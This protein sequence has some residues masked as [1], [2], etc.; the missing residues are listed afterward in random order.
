MQNGNERFSVGVLILRTTALEGAAPQRA[1]ETTALQEAEA[2]ALQAELEASSSRRELDRLSAVHAEAQQEMAQAQNETRQAVARADRLEASSNEMSRQ[3]A[4][5]EK[6]AAVL[7]D[8]VQGSLGKGK[9]TPIRIALC[10][11]CSFFGFQN[12]ALCL[13]VQV[14]Y[15]SSLK[16]CVPCPIAL[17]WR[18]WWASDKKLQCVVVSCSRLL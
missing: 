5:L 4:H 12:V 18:C 9:V 8:K 16:R 3:C 13:R 10:F 15:S 11:C 2:R 17:L 6:H 7:E 1:Q 14:S